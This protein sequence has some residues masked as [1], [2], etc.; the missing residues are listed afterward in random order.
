MM[1]GSCFMLSSRRIVVGVCADSWWWQRLSKQLEDLEVPFVEDFSKAVNSTD[2][3]ID[4]IFGRSCRKGASE[5][6]N[7]TQ[8]SPRL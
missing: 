3:I 7:H 6:E 1:L 4:A 8:I 5:K 2:H